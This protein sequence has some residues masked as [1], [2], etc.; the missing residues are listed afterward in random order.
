MK[1]RDVSVRIIIIILLAIAVVC[2]VQVA[3][4]IEWPWS[5]Y[6]NAMQTLAERNDSTVVAT[7]ALFIYE[8][9]QNKPVL[10]KVT[11]VHW[12]LFDPEKRIAVYQISFWG[13]AKDPLTHTALASHHRILARGSTAY[14]YWV[15]L[16]APVGGYRDELF[17]LDE[18]TANQLLVRGDA[19][20]EN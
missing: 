14:V 13:R 10:K 6:P 11:V 5:K 2:L 15:R 3:N 1:R 12:E 20:L 7:P 16:R 8:G 9:A 4:L 19:Q 17:L 18:V